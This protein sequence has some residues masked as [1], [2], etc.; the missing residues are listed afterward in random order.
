MVFSNK[1]LID[2]CPYS[3]RTYWRRVKS[4]KQNE[5]FKK[6]TEGDLLTLEDAMLLADKLGFKKEFEEFLK[7]NKH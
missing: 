5:T 7:H 2:L 6:T 3:E 1:S 4:L